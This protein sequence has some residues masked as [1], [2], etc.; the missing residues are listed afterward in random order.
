[1][2]KSLVWRVQ[3][4]DGATRIFERNVPSYL[5][6]GKQVEEVL[7]RLVSR[8]LTENEII[9]AS[10]NSRAKRTNL[11]EIRRAAKPPITISCGENP[12]YIA[13]VDESEIA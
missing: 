3:G 6:S 11:L 5:L 4:F 12:H 1:M 8:H 13:Y 2:V 9:G 7:K 10:L